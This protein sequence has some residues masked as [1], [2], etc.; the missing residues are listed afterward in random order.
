LTTMLVPV[1][2]AYAVA[3]GVPGIY[4]LGTVTRLGVRRRSGMSAS[5]L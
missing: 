3:S 5:V 2:M 4:G 1:G